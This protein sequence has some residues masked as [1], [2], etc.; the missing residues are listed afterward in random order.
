SMREIQHYLTRIRRAYLSVS[1]DKG[2]HKPSLASLSSVA[3]SSTGEIHHL[4]DKQ[5][6]E[7]DYEV[8]T[9]L[10]DA[11]SRVQALE[12]VESKRRAQLE[13]TSRFA[14]WLRD[15]DV[16]AQAA[17]L[18]AH[19]VSMTWYLNHF[20]V[21][22][23]NQHAEQRTIRFE[24]EEEKRRLAMPSS[25][26]F[27]APAYGYTL[28]PAEQAVSEQETE[29]A[30]LETLLSP[31]QLQQFE[32]E[33]TKMMQ[34]FE[35]SLQQIRTTQAKLAE[36][37]ELSTELQRHLEQ[38]TD[39][40][41]RLMEDATFT[42]MTVRQGNEQLGKARKRNAWYTKFVVTILLVLS[43]VLLFLDYYAS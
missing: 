10:R 39:M 2:H 26:R 41:D 38:Q 23:S 17:Q 33:N 20:L 3:S 4:T 43:F 22:L 29:A 27:Q 13:G 8:K 12:S 6:D 1:D 42:S 18:G 11:L 9:S 21:G 30:L 35:N 19:H 16:D 28:D 14:R 32:G 36:I 34:E 24:R 40:T 7:I 5:R 31:A 37:A 25:K 15:P